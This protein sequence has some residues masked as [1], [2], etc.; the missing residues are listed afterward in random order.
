MIDR[1]LDIY[2][3]VRDSVETHFSVNRVLSTP[4][5]SYASLPAMCLY[6]EDSRTDRI[7]QTTSLEESYANIT[8]RLEIA[9]TTKQE[10]RR[11]LALVDDEMMLLNFNRAGGQFV[12]TLGNK[13]IMRYVARYEAKVD[14]NGNLYRV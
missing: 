9:A 6:E 10:C 1:E 2:N 3:H 7:R 12:P 5:D 11:L 8:Y 14:K 4:I 13:A